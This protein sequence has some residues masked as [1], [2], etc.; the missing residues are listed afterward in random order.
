MWVTIVWLGLFVGTLVVGPGSIPG[1]RIGFWNQF[2]RLGCLSKPWGNER[3]L[4]LQWFVG[5]HR[6]PAPFWKEEEWVYEV[7]GRWVREQEDGGRGN[8]GWYEKY[9]LKKKTL[10]GTWHHDLLDFRIISF[11]LWCFLRL[12]CSCCIVIITIEPG[13]PIDTYSLYFDPL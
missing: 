6:R 1:T 8:C 7:D 10:S 4:V 2:P 12:I 9:N 3:S 5:S 11:V 13:H